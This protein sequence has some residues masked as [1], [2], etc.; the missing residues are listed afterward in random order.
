[1]TLSKFFEKRDFL[2]D[3]DMVKWRI[4]GWG[5]G[6]HVTWILLK[7][8]DSNQKLKNFPNLSKLGD[9]VSNR[10]GV[11][12]TKLEAKVKDT[13]KFRGQGQGQTLSR[14]RPRTQTQVF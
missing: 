2:W 5:L 10:G 14:P 3:K 4:R 12:D 8:K 9:V 13:K 11:E 7:G 1:M 6:W